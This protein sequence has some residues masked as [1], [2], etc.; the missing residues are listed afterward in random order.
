LSGTAFLQSWDFAVL[1][2]LVNF[3]QVSLASDID[4]MGWLLE[5]HDLRRERT[6][7]KLTGLLI[8]KTSPESFNKDIINPSALGIHA[9]LDVIIFEDTG[10]VSTGKLSTLVGIEHLRFRVLA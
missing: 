3:M 1:D 8:F 4:K 10:K 9:D 6:S 2:S 5:K 7:L